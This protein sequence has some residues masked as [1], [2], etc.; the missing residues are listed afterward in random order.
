MPG[1]LYAA[2]PL[3]L[4]EG[5]RRPGVLK[6]QAG[7]RA[8]DMCI[9]MY[10]E[11]AGVTCAARVVLRGIHV[12]SAASRT[13]D[14]VYCHGRKCF[15]GASKPFGHVRRLR[16]QAEHECLASP[17][18]TGTVAGDPNIPPPCVSC[19]SNLAHVWLTFGS[20]LARVWLAF[21]LRWLRLGDTSEALTSATWGVI[22]ANRQEKGVQRLFL[23]G[24]AEAG[25]RGKRGCGSVGGDH[26]NC[27]RRRCSRPGK[28]S[29]GT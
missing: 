14:S 9:W 5:V 17:T 12:N 10:L 16:R 11:A 15:L 3:L 1:T 2:N 24:N 6:K 22:Q 19:R 20:R 27:L 8:V 25:A 13:S 28:G 23:G 26:R 29:D 4:A 7:R 21:G 18:Q